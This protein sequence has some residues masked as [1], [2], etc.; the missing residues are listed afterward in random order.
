MPS[1]YPQFLSSLFFKLQGHQRMSPEAHLSLSCSGKMTSQFGYCLPVHVKLKKH[2][3][4][5]QLS[6]RIAEILPIAVVSKWV[7]TAQW[8]CLVNH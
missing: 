8:W 1:I 6:C 3:I 5:S 7:S 2:Y 4:K